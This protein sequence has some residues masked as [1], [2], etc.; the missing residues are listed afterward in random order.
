ML[1]KA[2]DVDAGGG[3]VDWGSCKYIEHFFSGTKSESRWT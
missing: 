1:P 2:S 3:W